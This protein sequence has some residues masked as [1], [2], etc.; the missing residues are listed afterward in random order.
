MFDFLMADFFMVE[1]N[2]NYFYNIL[3]KIKFSKGSILKWDFFVLKISLLANFIELSNPLTVFT[4][5]TLLPFI[6]YFSFLLYLLI[7][8]SI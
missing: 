8:P 3:I 4:L 7:H 5:F 6:F 1:D 2:A